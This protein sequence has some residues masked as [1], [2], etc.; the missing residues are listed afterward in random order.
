M[1]HSAWWRSRFFWK[2]Y[3]GF[4][5]VIALLALVMA[6][7]LSQIIAMH[8]AAEVQRALHDKALLLREIALPALRDWEGA[9]L[10]PAVQ[11]LDKDTETRYTVIRADGVVVADSE[12]DPQRMENHLHRPEVQQAGVQGWGLAQ[13]YS[14]TLRVD[15]MYYAVPVKSGDRT[16]GY[17]RAAMPLTTIAWHLAYLRGFAVLWLVVAASAAFI[18]AAAVAQRI[19]RPVVSMTGA[20]RSLACGD[21]STELRPSSSDEIGELAQAFNHLREE[22]RQRIDTIERER[23]QLSA[24]LCGMVEGVIAV[25]REERVVHL[26][27]VAAQ[28]FGVQPEQCLGMRLWEVIRVPAVVNT[29]SSAMQ[30]A[31]ATQMELTLAQTAKDI[32]LELHGSP[33]RDSHGAVAGA[34]LVLHDVTELRRLEIVRREFVANVSHELKTPLTAIHGFVETMLDDEQMSRET[35]QR[36][37]SKLRDQSARLAVLV[38][39]LLTLSR[40]ESEA[41]AVDQEPLDLREP[42]L[43][44]AQALAALAEERGLALTT[45]VPEDPVMVSGDHEALR[46]IVG[47]LLENAIKYTPAGGRV[48]LSVR[49]TS[50]QAV[51]EVVDTGIGI[52]PQEQQR[53]FERFYRVDKARSREL[54]GTGLG[55]SI[56]KHLALALGGQVSVES[57]PG[58]GSTFRVVL[59]Q[60]PPA[61]V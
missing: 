1:A 7:L 3:A 29:I 15:M 2:L 55:L 18:I 59:P 19:V 33:L 6:L 16:L 41:S 42:V 52:E 25:D 32:V 8:T 13:R 14:T 38:S 36:F 40:V 47:N 26:N 20:V 12:Q 45:D 34:V 9:G 48:G 46:Q 50:G 24:I 27:Q 61:G 37:L 17:T 5:G 57:T 23:N 58:R 53:I 28:A 43:E 10:G 22:L 30:S 44:S 31:A 49:R 56:V 39:D 35:Q 51:L 21:Y 4:V 60:L 11:H 54:G